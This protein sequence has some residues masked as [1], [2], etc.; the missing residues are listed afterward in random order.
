MAPSEEVNAAVGEAETLT[1]RAE[2]LRQTVARP[3]EKEAAQ[4]ELTE[5]ERLIAEREARALRAEAETRLLAIKRAY[6]SLADQITQ[7]D[8]RLIDAARKFEVA[9]TTESDRY[10]AIALLKHEAA[11]LAETFGL[12]TPELPTVTP[13]SERAAVVKAIG[14]VRVLA[15]LEQGVQAALLWGKDAQGRLRPVGRSFE[16]LEG[17]PGVDLIRRAKS[18]TP[19]RP[20]ADKSPPAQAR[21]AADVTL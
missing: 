18:Q 4:A 14:A 8:R 15:N 21:D 2:R 7:D 12:P 11:T 5:V 3:T 1:E 19:S 9:A 13:P 17:T 16:E 20:R 6:G 10:A